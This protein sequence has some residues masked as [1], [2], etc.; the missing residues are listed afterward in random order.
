MSCEAYIKSEIGDFTHALCLDVSGSCFTTTVLTSLLGSVAC[1]QSRI[2]KQIGCVDSDFDIA[3]VNTNF[4]FGERSGWR[5]DPQLPHT[6]ERVRLRGNAGDGLTCKIR[7]FT[8]IS[9]DQFINTA[10]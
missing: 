2:R 6:R 1:S 7:N 8:M 9:T 5:P 4:V 3:E 10:P